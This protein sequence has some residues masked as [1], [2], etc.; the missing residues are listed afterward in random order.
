MALSPWRRTASTMPPS[1]QCMALARILEAHGLVAFAV[2]GPIFL[3][4]HEQK[5]VDATIEHALQFGARPFADALDLPPTLAE[6]DRLLA[7][8]H[9]IDAL[10]DA[11]AAVPALF[12]AVGLDRRVVGQ[13]LMQLQKDLLARDLGG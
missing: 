1:L 9:H 11:H 2:L 7:R 8:P 10:L 13:L 4:A 5:E 3:D 12:P 6:H